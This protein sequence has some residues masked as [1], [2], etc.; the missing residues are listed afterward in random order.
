[1]HRVVNFF[2]ISGPR[3]TS[4][5]RSDMTTLKRWLGLS[6]LRVDWIEMMKSR[7]PSASPLPFNRRSLEH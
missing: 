4:N 2:R 6:R 7:L 1:M 3:L 5:V